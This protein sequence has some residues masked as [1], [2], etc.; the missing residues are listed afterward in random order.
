MIKKNTL[1]YLVRHG[2]TDWNIESRL[3]GQSDIPLNKKGEEQARQAAEKY[4]K[5]IHFDAVY[6]SDLV[7]AKKTA[8]IITLNK[9]I[10]I[11]TTKIL[12]E[13][14]FGPHEGKT[15]K[16]MEKE[17]KMDLEKLRTLSYKEAKKIGFETDDELMTRFLPF[18]RELALG[19]Q[20]KTVLLVSHGSVI[21]IFLEKTGFY[22]RE[23][24]KKVFV[25]NLGFVV[26]E[27]DGVEFW[28]KR[29]EGVRIEK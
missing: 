20:G 14:S 6:S 3:Q 23:Q 2:L 7:R 1:F 9:K 10:T 28:I 19:Y 4:F 21:R 18:I 27:S 29:V 13:R 26:F 11:E 16:Q 5:N 22:T 15:I 17:L 25:S 24:S 8:E 12:R